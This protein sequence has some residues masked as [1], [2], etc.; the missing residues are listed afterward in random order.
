M[1]S[2]CDIYMRNGLI[3][4]YEPAMEDSCY[5]GSQM[6]FAGESEPATALVHTNLIY[7]KIRI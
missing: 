1:S 6:E 5:M 7:F 2:P 4:E 3:D